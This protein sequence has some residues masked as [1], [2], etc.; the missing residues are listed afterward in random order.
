MLRVLTSFVLVVGFIWGAYFVAAHSAAPHEQAQLI[1][2]HY[3]LASAL[4][5]GLSVVGFVIPTRFALFT[6]PMWGG[7][8]NFLA[9]IWAAAAVGYLTI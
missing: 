8:F 7:W 3:G 9:A 1:G 2:A 5:W 4:A 6:G